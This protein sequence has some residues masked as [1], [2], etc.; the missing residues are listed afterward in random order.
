MQLC[1]N[2]LACGWLK[3]RSGTSDLRHKTAVNSSVKVNLQVGRSHLRVPFK[4][5]RQVLRSTEA[6]SENT[7]T[8][9]NKILLPSVMHSDVRDL[10]A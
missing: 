8:M 2:R 5:Q 9:K 1:E 3:V 6:F 7:P 4:K 10:Q